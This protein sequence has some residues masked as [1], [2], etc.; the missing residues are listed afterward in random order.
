[1]LNNAQV[2]QVYTMA[3]F[4]V[5]MGICIWLI[6]P[7]Q[8]RS[9]FIFLGLRNLTLFVLTCGLHYFRLSKHAVSNEVF[10]ALVALDVTVFLS[11]CYGGPNIREV[12][13]LLRHQQHGGAFA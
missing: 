11:V 10:G 12:I 7:D 4:F 6:K 2:I 8:D 3:V 1:M 13:A 5:M 9:A